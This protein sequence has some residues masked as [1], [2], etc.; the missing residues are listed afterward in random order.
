MPRERQERIYIGIGVFIFGAIVLAALSLVFM[1]KEYMHGKVETYTMF[2]KGSLNGLNVTSPI[3]YRGVK[4]GEVKRIE[5][6]ANKSK[7][8]VAIPVYVEFFVEKSFVQKDNPI[9]ILIDNGI[10]ATITAPNILTGTASIELV[11]SE[12]KQR[13]TPLIRT[14]HGYSMFPTETSNEDDMTANDTLRAA[15]KTLRDISNLIR[16]KEFK[17]TIVAIKDMAASIDKLAIAISERMP[18][19]FVYFNESMREVAK[20][21]YSVRN[22]SDY[23]SRHPESLLRGKS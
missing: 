8:N 12:N 4:I 23:L 15:R 19:T 16:S 6:T 9:Q 18:G 1:Y 5:L 7:S 13:T 21:A 14:F 10:V 22:L 17:D 11:P 20:A 3:T 2:F